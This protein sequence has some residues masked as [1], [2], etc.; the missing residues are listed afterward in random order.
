MRHP[1]F[2]GVGKAQCRFNSTVFADYVN[3]I[4]DI[5][6][7]FAENS[8]IHGQCSLSH[9]V[10]LKC[11]FEGE[12]SLFSGREPLA[13]HTRSPEHCGRRHLPG[14]KIHGFASAREFIVPCY[15]KVYAVE[16]VDFIFFH[17]LTALIIIVR[18]SA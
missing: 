15:K 11:N 13:G 12:L 6:A 18:H 17:L 8:I 5:P 1:D 14:F 16:A 10:L 3:F 4:A 9:R 2:V 7:W